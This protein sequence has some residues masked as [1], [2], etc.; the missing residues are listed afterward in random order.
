MNRIA[1]LFVAGLG[2]ATGIYAVMRAFSAGDAWAFYGWTIAAAFLFASA[3]V[4]RED[5]E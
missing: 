2:A 4:V 1:C 3:D 5:E